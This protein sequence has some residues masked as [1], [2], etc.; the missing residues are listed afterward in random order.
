MLAHVW[1]A[2]HWDSLIL[3]IKAAPRLVDPAFEEQLLF[4]L[5]LLSIDRQAANLLSSSLASLLVCGFSK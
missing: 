4:W 3:F 1:L 5:A 2:I